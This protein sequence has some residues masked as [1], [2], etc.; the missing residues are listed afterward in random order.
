MG[1]GRACRTFLFLM[2]GCSNGLLLQVLKLVAAQREEIILTT[3]GPPREP[4]PLPDGEEETDEMIRKRQGR[5]D[6]GPSEEARAKI[7]PYSEFLFITGRQ[8]SSLK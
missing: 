6:E 8:G 5:R 2:S 1:Q 7:E 3:D 4:T